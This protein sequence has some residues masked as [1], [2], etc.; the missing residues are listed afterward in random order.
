M[1]DSPARPKAEQ[2]PKQ[3]SKPAPLPHSEQHPE[4]VGI[5]L[6]GGRGMRS[7]GADKPLLSW[8]GRPLAMQVAQQLAPQVTN[9]VISAN[10][11]HA[12][13]LAL[14][15]S[16][17]GQLQTTAVSG[18]IKPKVQVVADKLPGFAGPLAGVQAAMAQ[19][20]EQWSFVCPGDAPGL[21]G[22]IVQKLWQHRQALTPVVIF[23]GTRQQHLHFLLPPGSG[24]KLTDYLAT[25]QRS[26]HG[27][28]EHCGSQQFSYLDPNAFQNVNRLK[29]QH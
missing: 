1:S 7:G 29:P 6:C 8:Q 24:H 25:G 16:V 12:R 22:D 3:D 14:A 27:F 28:H 5:I 21:P 4:V 13:Y 15:E 9:L 20:N 11:N 10:R 23:D 19:A 17:E 2:D 18:S 26:A